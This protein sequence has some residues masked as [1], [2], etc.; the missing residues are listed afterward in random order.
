[1][2]ALSAYNRRVRKPGLY[3]PSGVPKIDWMHPITLGLAGCWLPGI[4]PCYNLVNGVAA[5]RTGSHRS[6][7]ETYGPAADFAGGD[8]NYFTVSPGAILAGQANFSIV[9]Q[10][11]AR[12][13]GEVNAGNPIYCERVAAGNAILKLNQANYGGLGGPLEFT[14]RNDGGT[15]LQYKPSGSTISDTGMHVFGLSKSNATGGVRMFNDGAMLGAATSWVSNDTLTSSPVYIAFEP[16]DAKGWW[17]P[18][19][20][21]AV[22]KRA[23]SDSEQA[24]LSRNLFQFL[25]PCEAGL[26]VLHFASAFAAH[27]FFNVF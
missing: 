12:S 10:A 4:E 17:G 27:R 22:W 25:I 20:F 8:A 5:P 11:Q 18:I 21:V 9:A 6:K 24:S 26:P 19:S 23:L 14:Y 15:L 13:V 1:M 3:V 7:L 16:A 2:Q